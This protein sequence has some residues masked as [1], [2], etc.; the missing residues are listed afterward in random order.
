MAD[1][2]RSGRF[3][4]PWPAPP[5]HRPG[6][7]HS[8][9][10]TC[11][12]L[13]ASMH[14]DRLARPSGR[15]AQDHRVDPRLLQRSR[16]ARSSRAA[17][18]CCPATAW[19]GSIRRPTTETTSTPSIFF[20]PSRCFSP[21]AP[22]PARC[23]LHVQLLRWGDGG[24]GGGGG[25][26]G[27]A[28]WRPAAGWR[29]LFRVSGGTRARARRPALSRPARSAAFTSPVDVLPRITAP[30]TGLGMGK[31]GQVGG[32]GKENEI[33]ITFEHDMADR[34]VAARHM[35]MPVQ[36]AALPCPARRA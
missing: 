9:I 1:H 14:C 20:R 3:P 31:D 30:G 33:E 2:R 15:R 19:V 23:D 13:P 26:L 8:G 4:A 5:R 35:V 10:S 16:P 32:L 21:N 22:A 17:M 11:T 25:G 6:C 34:A 24:G 29:R 28:E 7:R 12:C 18:P 27:V 36:R